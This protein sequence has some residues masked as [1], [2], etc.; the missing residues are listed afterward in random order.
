MSKS[1]QQPGSLQFQERDL[2]LLRGLFESRLMTATQTT[3][4]FFEGKKEATKKRLQKLKKAHLLGERKRRVNESSIL[5]LTRNAV[6]L[7]AREGALANYPSYRLASW[8]KRAAVSD[9]TLRHEL[10]VM[11]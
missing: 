8:D 6:Q 11:D 2:A 4:L 10:E 7:L 3:T 1:N 9:F 5:F